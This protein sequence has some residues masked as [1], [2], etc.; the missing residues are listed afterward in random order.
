MLD[1]IDMD[2]IS[3]APSVLEE[4]VESPSSRKKLEKLEAVAYAG[5]MC[6]F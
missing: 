6:N 1:R 2:M 4:L 5:G 3:V